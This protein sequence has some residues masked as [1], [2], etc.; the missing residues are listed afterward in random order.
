MPRLPMLFSISVIEARFQI[1][2]SF[3][4]DNLYYR[5]KEGNFMPL[6]FKLISLFPIKGTRPFPIIW[7]NLCPSLPLN[8]WD[9]YQMLWEEF[10]F[11]SVIF[12]SYQGTGCM[13]KKVGNIQRKVPLFNNLCLCSFVEV[14]FITFTFGFKITCLYHL[15]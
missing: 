5:N 14:N 7:F 4:V 1:A 10:F 12:I 9:F 15:D 13:A 2:C 8:K 3:V 6:K 11:R